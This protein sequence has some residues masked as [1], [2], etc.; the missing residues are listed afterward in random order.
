MILPF[1]DN[2]IIYQY[3]YLDTVSDIQRLTYS[4]YVKAI[5]QLDFSHYTITIIKNPKKE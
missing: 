3:P 5:K 2:V 1:V 4:H